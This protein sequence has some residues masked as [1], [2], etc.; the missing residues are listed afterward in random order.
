MSDIKKSIFTDSEKSDQVAKHG[1]QRQKLARLKK[2]QDHGLGLFLHFGISTYDGLEFSPGDLPPSEFN[3]TKLDIAQW[4]SLARDA[5]MKYAILTV[6][7]VSGFC[8]WP[9]N[10]TNYSVA[11]SGTKTDILSVFIEECEKKGVMPGIYYCTWDN[12]NSFGSLMPNPE[13]GIWNEAYTS[14]KY[15]DFMLLQIEELLTRYG[16]IFEFWL[17]IPFLLT[18]GF[19]R[20]VYDR[21]A[22]LQPET[23]ILMNHGLRDGSELD[24]ASVWPT[25]LLSIERILPPSAT[26]H[27]PWRSVLGEDYYIPGEVCETVGKDWFYKEEDKPRCN[28]ELVGMYQIARARGTNLLLNVGPD[29]TGLI[30]RDFAKSL[31]ALGKSI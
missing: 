28:S 13:K 6:K 10:Y 3:P 30:P 24:V 11:N 23:F 14:R 8:L 18:G 25:D 19:R 17:D 26:G 27:I 7:H 5:G 4:A 1:A 15:Q 9:S 31:Q 22:E 20:V 29:K 12:H 21:I 16:K 2:W